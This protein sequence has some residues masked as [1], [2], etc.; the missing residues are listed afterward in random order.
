MSAGV[1]AEPPVVGAPAPGREPGE[2]RRYAVAAGFLAP[3]LVA[4]GVWIVY[5]AVYT[6]Y[7]SLFDKS[8]SSYVCPSS[9]LIWFH[10]YHTL[11]SDSSIRT[12]IKNNAIWIGVVPA[13]VT[14]IGLVFAVLTE[15]VSWSV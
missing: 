11:F 12:A 15:R 13:L 3:A 2:W 5:P 14:A 4:L 10:N 6:V 9:H 8:C 7:R 1:T